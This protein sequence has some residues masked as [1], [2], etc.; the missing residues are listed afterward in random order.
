LPGYLVAL[1][2]IQPQGTA[3]TGRT[4][5]ASTI[6]LP[7]GTTVAAAREL[8]TNGTAGTPAV[9]AAFLSTVR[10]VSVVFLIFPLY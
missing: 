5:D 6:F 1:L 7:F 3:R 9:I 10:R 8:R 4:F 2:A